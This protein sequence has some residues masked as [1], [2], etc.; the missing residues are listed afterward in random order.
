M[1]KNLS[2]MKPVVVPEKLYFKKQRESQNKIVK[3][4]ADTN[5]VVQENRLFIFLL[6]MYW[7][8]AMEMCSF[9]LVVSIAAKSPDTR[10]NLIVKCRVYGK[11]MLKGRNRAS[12][13]GKI[14]IKARA[15]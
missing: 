5:P 10:N 2:G 6:L 7:I 4:K 8:T 3:R 14:A 15:E 13:T 12:A 1:A 9:A 11:K